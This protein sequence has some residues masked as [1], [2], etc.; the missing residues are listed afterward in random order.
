MQML[1]GYKT[2][3]LAVMT[4]LYAWVGFFYGG[5]PS[6]I[7]HTDIGTAIALTLAAATVC[8]LRAGIANEVKV[9]LA[10]LGIQLPNTSSVQ[11]KLA[12]AA[13]QAKKIAPVL[14]LGFVLILSSGLQGCAATGGGLTPQQTLQAVEAGFAMAEATYDA[15]CSVNAPPT[16]CTDASNQA[17]YA[18]AKQALEAAFATAQAAITASGNMDSAS[19]DALLNAVAQDWATYNGLVNGVKA[20]DAARRGVVFVPIPLR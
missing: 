6:T 14:A 10:G 17:N 13:Q 12:A 5:P 19:I 9:L 3:V 2:Y 11:A 15:I 20:K 18:K 4:A 7:P 16:F 8:G 1:Q